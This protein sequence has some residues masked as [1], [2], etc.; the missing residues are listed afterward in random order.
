MTD[1]TSQAEPRW[2]ADPDA[3]L[4]ILDLMPDAATITRLADGS[5]LMANP[6]AAAMYGWPLAEMIGRTTLE[7][8]LFRNAA[9]RQRMLGLLSQRDAFRNHESPFWNRSGQQREGM[10]SARVFRPGDEPGTKRKVFT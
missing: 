1:A 5:M 3:A 6:A 4:A 9:E 10:F 2:L 7:L 8:G